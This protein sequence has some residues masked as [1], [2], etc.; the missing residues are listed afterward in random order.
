M[1]YGR[2]ISFFF[3]DFGD[4]K[5][6]SLSLHQWLSAADTTSLQKTQLHW[7]DT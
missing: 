6:H 2:P 4:V 3:Y 7:D 5:E 1:K